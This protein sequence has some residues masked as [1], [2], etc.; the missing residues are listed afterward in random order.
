M[1]EP[2]E[3]QQAGA[4]SDNTTLTAVLDELRAD[5]WDDDAFALEGGRIKWRCGHEEPAGDVEVGCIRRMEGASDP[6]DMLAV[7]AGACPRCGH[8]GVLVTHYGP[9]AGPAD[10]DVL[11]S[12]R[13]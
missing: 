12:L 5:G 6:D 9:T 7:V 4:P 1:S 2:A 8:R 13:L 3:G 11:A 10:A